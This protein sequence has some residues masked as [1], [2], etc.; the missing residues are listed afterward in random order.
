M[1]GQRPEKIGLQRKFYTSLN[2]NWNILKRALINEAEKTKQIS[3]KLSYTFFFSCIRYFIFG[4]IAF[5]N[6]VLL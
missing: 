6:T 5:A 1:H 3:L 4:S 2:C